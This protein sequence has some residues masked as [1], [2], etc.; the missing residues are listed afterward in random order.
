MHNNS[1]PPE[2]IRN[3]NNHQT[4]INQYANQRNAII[5]PGYID[6]VKMSKNTRILS[7]NPNG[8]NPWDDIQNNMINQSFQQKQID[9]ALFN[10]TNIKWTPTNLD[11]I[12]Q[13]FK[14]NNWEVKVIGC[15][16]KKWDLTTNNYL[17]GGLLIVV[18]GKC[19]SLLQD[20]HICKSNLGNWMA[21]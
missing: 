16:S 8:I 3:T 1:L 4:R 6:N 15:D 12:E 13:E 20:E 17:P 2:E 21:I 11:K 5:H 19:R 9:I 18:Q 14:K 7:I 10:E